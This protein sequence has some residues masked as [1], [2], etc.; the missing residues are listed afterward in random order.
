MKGEVAFVFTAD[1]R[2]I[3]ELLSGK[4]T[5]FENTGVL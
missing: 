2:G 4:K 1:D 5:A 3:S